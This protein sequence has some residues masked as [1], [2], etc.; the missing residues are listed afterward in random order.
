VVSCATVKDES[1]PLE[2]L[3]V[4]LEEA[5]AAGEREPEAMALATVGALAAPSVRIV[6]CRGIGTDGLHFFTNYESR[7]GRELA[8]NPRAAVAFHWKTLER[9]ARV[10]GEVSK[11]AA[12]DSDS[13]FSHRARGSQLGAWASPQS[14]PIESLDEVLRR[15]EELAAK[16]E[17]REVP[18]PPHWGGYL[19]RASAV[20][21]WKGGAD[22]IHERLRYDRDP[23]GGWSKQRLGP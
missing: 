5:R 8:A 16:Y 3:S 18:R 7:K 2:L 9:Q 10:E 13:Y 11:L 12:A 17:G 20:E 22:R 4:W 1:S 14:Q 19:L 21:L 15:Q 6:L 23:S